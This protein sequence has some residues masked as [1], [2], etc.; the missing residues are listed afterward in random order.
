MGSSSSKNRDTEGK[1]RSARI[2]EE[3]RQSKAVLRDEVKLLLVGP[4]ESGK[5]TILKQISL[6]YR[7]ECS[8]AERQRYVEIVRSNVY[9]N[10]RLIKVKPMSKDVITGYIELEIIVPYELLAAATL[11]MDQ[12]TL[13]DVVDDPSSLCE[14]L[15]SA[16][17]KIWEHEETRRVMQRSNEF[18]ISDSAAYFFDSL[19]RLTSP[20]YLPT[21]DDILRTR[22]R[23]IGITE[24]IFPLPQTPS[25]RVRVVDVGGQ[26]SERKKWI[27]CFE[28]VNVLL[29]VAAVSEYDQKLFEDKSTNRL[30]ESFVVIMSALRSSGLA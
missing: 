30:E 26:R 14:E 29:F 8:E 27:N 18:Q 22:V 12:E 11:V 1:A 5:S 10:M 16:M 19:P 25:T 17:S 13:H 7:G 2:D 24:V 20:T 9:H 4:G 21:T 15:V 23:S 3:L 6:A 28:N